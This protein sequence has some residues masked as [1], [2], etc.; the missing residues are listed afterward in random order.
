MSG[1]AHPSPNARHGGNPILWTV[2]LVS[3]LAG[4]VAAFMIVAGVGITCQ[5]IFLRFVLNVSTIWQTEAVT[6]LLIGATLLGLPYV[7]Y[8][9]GH[10]NVDLLAHLLPPA[11]QRVL[12]AVTLTLT[13]AMTGLMLWTGYGFWHE[14]WDWGERSNTP[15]DPQLWVPYLALPLGFG[16]Y[17]L[18]LSADFLAVV[19]GIDVTIAGDDREAGAPE[20]ADAAIPSDRAGA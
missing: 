19:L 17:L 6:Y 20:P 12:A 2:G 9:R 7:Q 10:V 13:M 15:W 16:L 1:T 11:G 8:L 4:V 5:M 14:A 3:R 18:Q